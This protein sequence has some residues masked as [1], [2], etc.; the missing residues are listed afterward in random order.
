MPVSNQ[1]LFLSLS[2]GLNDSHL[3]SSLGIGPFSTLTLHTPFYGGA[4]DD[5][6]GATSSTVKD[7]LVEGVESESDDE[8]SECFIDSD[9]DVDDKIEK[10][11]PNH[12]FFE[13]RRKRLAAEIEDKCFSAMF[14]IAEEKL[15]ADMK[16]MNEQEYAKLLEE[17]NKKAMDDELKEVEEDSKQAEKKA[18]KEAKKKAKKAR[19]ELDM[20]AEEGKEG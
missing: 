15:L 1:R 10:K 7:E 13:I 19:K 8:A 6:I 16:L 11:L 14:K 9:S 20:K 2:L 12:N 4:D 3:I 18:K 17:E 5:T